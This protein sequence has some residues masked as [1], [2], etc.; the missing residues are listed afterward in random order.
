[1]AAVRTHLLDTAGAEVVLL[2]FTRSLGLSSLVHKGAPVVDGNVNDVGVV[3]HVL[4]LVRNF[5]LH[6]RD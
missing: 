2:F 5:K 4:V 1:M 6:P 3:S